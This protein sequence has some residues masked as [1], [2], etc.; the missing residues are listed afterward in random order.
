M[1]FPVGFTLGCLP[2]QEAKSQA[3][4]FEDVRLNLL[5]NAWS[6]AVVGF[7]VLQLLRPLQLWCCPGTD[8]GKALAAK[9]M[10]LLSS[11]GSDIMIYEMRAVYTALRWRVLRRQECRVRFV[12]LTDSM[13]SLHVINRGRSSSRKLQSLMYRLSSLLLAAGLHP[14]LA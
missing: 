2:K 11:K 12:H 13:V 7:L 3:L 10:T 9:L 6:V 8:T 4:R 1:G 5:G 14:F